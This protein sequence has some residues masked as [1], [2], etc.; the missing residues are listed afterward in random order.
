MVRVLLPLV[1]YMGY[2]AGA[3]VWTLS[4]TEQALW[5]RMETLWAKQAEFQVPRVSYGIMVTAYECAPVFST[6]ILN[7]IRANLAFADTL[8]DALLYGSSYFHVRAGLY[9]SAETFR[10]YTED[11]CVSGSTDIDGNPLWYTQAECRATFR[12]G[13]LGRSGIKAAL[14]EFVQMAG[15]LITE[16]L[17]QQVVR[18]NG[19]C[20]TLNLNTGPQSEVLALA[21]RFL[22]PALAQASATRYEEGLSALRAFLAADTAVA[23]TAVLFL[24]VVYAGVYRPLIMRLDREIKETRALL[25]LFPDEV[26]RAVPAIV[27][28]TRALSN[29]EGG[30]GSGVA[31]AGSG[32]LSA[33]LAGGAEGRGGRGRGLAVMDV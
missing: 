22:A 19:S 2:F 17:A 13:V 14:T 1:A 25:L 15:R 5:A 6:E 26:C 18:V 29:Q 21:E 10:L 9:S 30:R 27:A 20:P 16:R 11:G 7:R 8:Q 32:Q 28:L 12:N 3:Y 33:S 24:L 23:V 31:A 4:A